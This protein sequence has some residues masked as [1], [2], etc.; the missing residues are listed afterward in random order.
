MDVKRIRLD[1]DDRQD[2]GAVLTLDNA[3]DI[4]SSY[5][6]TRH[7]NLRCFPKC[8]PAHKTKSFCGMPLYLSA[9]L[10]AAGSMLV[11]EFRNAATPP[12]LRV[13]SVCDA[14]TLLDNKYFEGVQEDEGRGRWVV[15]P[16]RKWRYEG[17]TS[18]VDYHLL[19]MYLVS[20]GVVVDMVNT[21]KFR[22]I[23]IWRIVEEPKLP[24]AVVAAAAS[25]L[26]APLV[27][28]GRQAIEDE[29][30]AVLACLAHKTTFSLSP[31]AQA[32]FPM[33][34]LFP[35][36][37]NSYAF[38][39]SNS[40]LAPSSISPLPSP[41]AMSNLAS[42]LYQRFPQLQPHLLSAP[43]HFVVNPRN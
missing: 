15:N 32:R 6:R 23:P 41:L 25:S 17:K 30:R 28:K 14:Q 31:P 11:A 37:S 40:L 27:D 34:S 18:A 36:N 20:N 22:V 13:D 42:A 21:P 4:Q 39:P 9:P 8:S 29:A 26:S 10:V 3:K 19:T 12:S 24:V 35:P 1:G 43:S 2:A 16:P 7:N 38:P 5:V 33:L